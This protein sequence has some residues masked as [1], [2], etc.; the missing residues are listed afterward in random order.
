MVDFFRR[1]AVL[2][3]VPPVYIDVSLPGG[4]VTEE[5]FISVAG[6]DKV[7]ENR[8]HCVQADGQGIVLCQV[9]GRFHALEN[10]C[11][12]GDSTFEKGRVRAHKLLCPLHGGIFD[13]R[14]GAVLGPPALKPLRTYPV[15]VHDRMIQVCLAGPATG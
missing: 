14:D 10:R 2:A 7:P 5:R 9:A 13:V 3:F 1:G 4:P 8:V 12:H 11:S 15:R 6:V